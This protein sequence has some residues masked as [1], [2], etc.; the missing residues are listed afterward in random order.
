MCYFCYRF[1][2]TPQV[3]QHVQTITLSTQCPLPTSSPQKTRVCSMVSD[4]LSQLTAVFVPSGNPLPRE[5]R[6]PL[7]LK[8]RR[9]KDMPI[10]MSSS[11]ECCHRWRWCRIDPGRCTVM[12]LEQDRWTKLSEHTANHVYCLI[13]LRVQ[14]IF[15]VF[16]YMW[17]LS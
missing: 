7:T 3:E 15:V 4:P 2:S 10:K 11:T 9:G 17:P 5:L 12:K 16:A 13:L 14:T 1:Y 6:T 8:W